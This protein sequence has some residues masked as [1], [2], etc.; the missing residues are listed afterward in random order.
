MFYRNKYKKADKKHLKA[1]SKIRAEG[2]KRYFCHA[3]FHSLLFSPYGKIM[4]CYNNKRE[5]LG[6]WPE[7]SISDVWF[8]KKLSQLREHLKHYDLSYGCDDCSRNLHAGSYYSVGAWRYDYLAG[9]VGKF[10]TS[11]DFQMSSRCNL[12]CIMCSGENS[13][14]IRMEKELAAPYDNPYDYSFLEQLNEF[15]PYLRDASFSGGE[16][17]LNPVYYQIWDLF[18]KN[19]PNIRISVNS[20]GTILNEKVK[21]VLAKLKFNITLSIDAIDKEI[22]ASIRRGANLQ[23]TLENFEYYLKYT[24]ANGTDINIKVCPIKQNIYHIPDLLRFFMAHQVP[25]IYNTVV[26][27]PNCTIWN[28]PAKQIHEAI[29]HLQ[30]NRPVSATQSDKDNIARYDSLIV[31]LSN[32]HTEALVREKNEKQHEG[33]HQKLITELLINIEAS[34]SSIPYFPNEIKDKKIEEISKK[35]HG[36]FDAVLEDEKKIK[37][38]IYFLSLPVERLIGEVD[39]REL[40]KLIYRVNGIGN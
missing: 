39:I 30:K 10:P 40:D 33:N 12:Q 23:K 15:V 37:I 19:N 5:V 13:D 25:V 11:F 26:F 7:D 34:I 6:T 36:I 35:I 9:K 32:W 22:Y 24:R 21:S 14:K 2:K 18:A 27:P 17:F 38:A 28:Q 3:P 29:D 4:A 1:Y 20:N 8:G 16:T 31:Q